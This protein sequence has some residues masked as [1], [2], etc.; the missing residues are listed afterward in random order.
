MPDQITVKADQKA[1]SYVLP[2][3]GSQHAVTVDVIDLG[4]TADQYEN[5]P[6]RVIH[7]IALVFQ[8]DEESEPGKRFEV[9]R[10]F[11]V[12]QE[13]EDGRQVATFGPRSNL[14][15]FLGDWR[16]KPY[17]DAEAAE[18]AP[19]HK[20]V[21][22]N[23]M[24]NILHEQSKKNPDRTYA[25]VT[26]AQSLPKGLAKIVPNKYERS[27]YWT[28]KKAEYAE[29]LAAYRATHTGG[30]TANMDE[31]PPALQDDSD[32]LPF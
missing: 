27:D 20:L 15:K 12:G 23:A 3:S 22:V 26:G 14:R 32:D 28:Q 11:S 31:L 25:K 5:Q 30:A 18:G 19:L 6:I 2:P 24:L 21:G 1:T 7:K 9:S 16:G 17:T 4:W 29:K 13:F 10:E 8:L